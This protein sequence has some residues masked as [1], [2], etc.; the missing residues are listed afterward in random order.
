M[1]QKPT[2]HTACATPAR[3]PTASFWL[4]TGASTESKLVLSFCAMLAICCAA[5]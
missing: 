1:I 2:W 4:S 3:S 5:Q